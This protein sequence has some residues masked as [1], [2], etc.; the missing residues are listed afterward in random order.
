VSDSE[1]RALAGLARL[2]HLNLHG[3]QVS[4]AG[5]DALR[6]LAALRVLYLWETRVTPAGRSALEESRPGLRV[7]GGAGRSPE[8]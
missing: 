1:L 7:F 3:T 8:P 6:P 5:L 4:D 2:E